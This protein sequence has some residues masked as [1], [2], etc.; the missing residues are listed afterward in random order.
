M[1]IYIIIYII[2]FIFS[3]IERLDDEKEISGI[4]TKRMLFYC[5]SILL[6]CFAGLRY[7]TGP[8]YESYKAIYN[9]ASDTLNFADRFEPGFVLFVHILRNI[10]GVSFETFL[11]AFTFVNITVK[12]G[13]FK[14]YFR[15]PIFLMLMYY[16]FIFFLV[17]FGQIRQGMAL[18]IILWSIPAVM[19]R[20]ILQFYVIWIIACS[21]H[22]SML[23]FFPFYFLGQITLSKKW[24]FSI[25]FIGFIFNL[26]DISK[27]ILFGISKIIGH[28]SLGA[29]IEYMM[30]YGGV[31]T[32][33]IVYYFLQPSTIIN[34]FLLLVF[35]Y[36]YKDENEN[37]MART[38][39]NLDLFI[40]L[41]VKFFT[42]FMILQ[43]R[44]S[45]F[46]KLFE[47]FI[48]YYILDKVTR[49]EEKA[50][51]ISAVFFYGLMRMINEFLRFSAMYDDYKFFS[52]FL[53]F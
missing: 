42:D 4:L 38:I 10:I 28:S 16:P 24:F 7:F 36:Y 15:Y 53:G 3:L 26:F 1:F 29:I 21:F 9:S 13:F 45:Y 39:Y 35:Q 5:V 2:L 17:D 41:I 19:N 12:A 6:I 49:K 50:V 46:Y 30:N 23:I 14:K 27:A 11:F 33:L 52:S 22:Y 31:E 32:N 44:G 48:I 43:Q 40:I 47:I 51:V 37:S 8:D 20:K 25:F 18:G 34:I